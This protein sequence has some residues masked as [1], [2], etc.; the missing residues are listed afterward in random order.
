MIS[1]SLTKELLILALSRV[2]MTT[3]WTLF[4][5]SIHLTSVML[6]VTPNLPSKDMVSCLLI[7]CMVRKLILR[8]ECGLV[9]LILVHFSLWLMLLKSDLRTW[10]MKRQSGLLL[11]SLLVLRPFSKSPSTAM[12]LLMWRNLAVAI[13]SNTITLLMSHL[14]THLSVQL[15]LWTLLIWLL[16]V[17]ISNALTTTALILLLDLVLINLIKPFMY[18][19]RELVLLRSA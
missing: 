5:L 11:L 8:T 9:L 4:P 2:L 12:T 15:R 19:L 6:L 13:V 7:L 17:L 1:S 16:M 3:T 14:L 10:K 18:V